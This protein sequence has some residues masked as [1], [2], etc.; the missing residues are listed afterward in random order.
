VTHVTPHLSEFSAGEILRGSSNPT[1]IVEKV[2]LRWDYRR[3]AVRDLLLDCAGV[4]SKARPAAAK[5]PLP[6]SK[7]GI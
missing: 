1:D 3:A 7:A 2:H 5:E 6:V 4:I